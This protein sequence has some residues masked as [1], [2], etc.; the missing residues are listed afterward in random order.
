MNKVLASAVASVIG[1][2]AFAAG[3]SEPVPMAPPAVAAYDWSG[4]YIGLQFGALDGDLDLAGENLNNN[5]TTAAGIG[6]SGQEL[7]LYGGY[8]WVGANNLVFGVDG[9]INTSN[10]DGFNPGVPGP[11]FGFIRNGIDA[12]IDGTAALRGRVGFA[13]DRGLFY[14]T[15]GVAWAKVSLDGTPGGGGGGGGSGPFNPSETLAGWTIGAGYEHAINDQ[16]TFRLDYRYSDLDGDFGFLSGGGGGG[17]D[18]HDFDLDLESHQVR[19]GAAYR[20]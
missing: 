13:M 12:E 15:A 17:P 16:W 5:N 10:A 1:T 18:P 20:F 8:N 3:L 9:E 11:S 14:L 7:G 6:V 19:I 2:S 4:G